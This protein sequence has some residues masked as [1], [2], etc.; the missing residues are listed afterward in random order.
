MLLYLN[1]VHLVHTLDTPQTAWNNLHMKRRIPQQ[2]RNKLS[3]IYLVGLIVVL[4]V[5][6]M[7]YRGVRKEAGN[8]IVLS[9]SDVPRISAADAITAVREQGAILVD[10]RTAAQYEAGHAWG[11]ISMP[12]AEIETWLD[13]LDKEAWYIN[14]CT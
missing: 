12:F 13:T 7:I 6:F 3:P 8:P 5:G 10:T 11:S 2:N 4:V 1:R 9:A 14:Y